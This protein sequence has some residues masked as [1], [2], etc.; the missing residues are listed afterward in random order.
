[1]VAKAEVEAAKK[2]EMEKVV[3]EDGSDDS[4][5]DAPG[6]DGELTEEQKKVAEAAGLGD[7][8]DKQVKQSRSE[9]KVC[10]HDYA[11]SFIV[12]VLGM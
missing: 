11:I 6:L 10:F 9:K 5:D 3:V 8:M 7:Q 2:E 1:M 4:D 12:I